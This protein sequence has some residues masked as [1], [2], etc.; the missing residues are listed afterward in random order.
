M[1]VYRCAGCGA[2]SPQWTGR[3]PGCG[4][5]NTLGE[6]R[7]APASAATGRPVQ[8]AVPIARVD[9]VEWAHR[10]TGIDELDRVL[11][12]GLVPGSVTLLGGEPGIGKSTLLL[13]M[14]AARARAG[15]PSSTCRPRSPDPQ[16]RLRAERLG[17]L[18]DRLWFASE[19]SLPDLIA[20]LDQ[21][22]PEVFVVDSIQT[23][24]RSRRSARAPGSV[25][26]VR[27]C[28][29][30]A[31]AGGQG[32]RRRHGARRPRHEGRRAGRAPRARAPRR[33]RA[34]V[35]GRPPP[36]A[37]AAPRGQAPLR[38]H[39]RAGPV[40]DDRRGPRAGARSVGAVP[41]RP[42][43][44]RRRARW[45]C[46]TIEGHRPLLVEIQ[47]LLVDRA[48]IGGPPGRPG[49]RLRA[50]SRCSPPCSSSGPASRSGEHDVYA[51]AVGGVQGGRA[52][53]RP[54][55][56]CSRSRRRS[57]DVAVPADLV[58]CGE[59]G[60]GGEIRQVGQL[61]RRL[62][63]AARLGFR[64]A[65]VPPSAPESAGRHR[66]ASGCAPLAEAIERAGLRPSA[67]VAV[68]EVA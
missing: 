44:R 19:T 45:S 11:G 53:R 7:T 5:W 27:E 47:A 10:S 28:G 66:G 49:P 56:S 20:H 15:P 31:R 57:T 24:A 9:A 43:G 29:P 64:R 30:P 39:R 26:Q 38:L 32:A 48:A 16:V 46:P 59:V 13:Q 62:A 36:R 18:P 37:A 4:A 23:V 33:H 65:L 6:E 42:P 25:G 58:A 35:R 3:C 21:V 14:A 55:R 34:V 2:A 51:L 67:A 8:A 12:G 61:E 41:R 63:E 60:L 54:R 52:R 17:A 50:G 1:A 40:R 22:R 68:T